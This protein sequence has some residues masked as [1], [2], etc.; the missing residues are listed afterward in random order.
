MK[1]ANHRRKKGKKRKE[2]KEREKGKGK[3]RDRTGR[4]PVC[5]VREEYFVQALFI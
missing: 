2:E 1:G 5:K 4:C 3:E